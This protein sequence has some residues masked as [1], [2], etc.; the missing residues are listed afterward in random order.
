[1]WTNS[2]NS[3][4]IRPQAIEISGD[5]VILRKEFVLVEATDEAPAHYKYKEW[6][7]TKK[8]YDIYKNFEER[9]REQDDALVELAELISEVI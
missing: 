3:E 7:M 1:M 4:N 8:Q 6:Q 5:H 9:I 2:E